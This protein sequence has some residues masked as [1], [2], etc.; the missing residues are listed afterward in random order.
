M[1]YGS[2][3]TACAKLDSIQSWKEKIREG[4]DGG[5]GQ[6]LPAPRKIHHIFHMIIWTTVMD[7]W[8]LNLCKVWMKRLLETLHFFSI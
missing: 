7:N 4:A 5:P 6:G 2:R 3:Q 1:S 8:F